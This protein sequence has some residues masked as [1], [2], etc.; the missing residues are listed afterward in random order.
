ML[1]NSKIIDKYSKTKIGT[2][3]KNKMYDI[4]CSEEVIANTLSCLDTD[5]KYKKM[6][7]AFDNGVRTEQDIM[8]CCVYID[9]DM[10]IE[11]KKSASRSC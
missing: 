5:D 3:L 2:Q 11:Y 4:G 1:T 7:E 10:D 9:R 6:L 8:L